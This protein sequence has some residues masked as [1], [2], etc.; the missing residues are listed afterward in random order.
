MAVKLKV[1]LNVKQN[2]LGSFGEIERVAVADPFATDYS[3]SHRPRVLSVAL[4]S[5]GMSQKHA[6]VSP[7]VQNVNPGFAGRRHTR[8]DGS[9]H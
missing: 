9:G 8:V 6:A 4:D 3:R 5:S 2:G 7:A 1:A